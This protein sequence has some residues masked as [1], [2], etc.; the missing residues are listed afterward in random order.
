MYI[1]TRINGAGKI[2][3]KLHKGFAYP[4]LVGDLKTI[5]CVESINPRPHKN[6]RISKYLN[7]ECNNNY[8]FNSLTE[9]VN[10]NFTRVEDIKPIIS[11]LE[12]GEW[13]DVSKY[14]KY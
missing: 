5:I 4:K 3:V 9:W 13:V 11:E 10:K 1:E 6:L 2:I 8:D 12:E 7:E 14:Q